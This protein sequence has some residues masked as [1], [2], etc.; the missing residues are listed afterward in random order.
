MS[1]ELSKTEA[2]KTEGAP[3][4]VHWPDFGHRANGLAL[5]AFVNVDERRKVLG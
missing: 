3:A 2:L 5:G 1:S 4:Y